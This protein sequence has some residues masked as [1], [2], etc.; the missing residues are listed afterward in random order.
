MWGWVRPCGYVKSGDL[1]IGQPNVEF[2]TRGGAWSR[3]Q[4][5][6]PILAVQVEVPLRYQ[7]LLIHPSKPPVT[8]GK[9]GTEY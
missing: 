4:L 7:P 6:L 2:E 1:S 8:V 5:E 3:K 9:V